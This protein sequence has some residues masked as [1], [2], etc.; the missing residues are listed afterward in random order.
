MRSCNVIT[1]VIM[2]SY[3]VTAIISN[4][5]IFRLTKLIK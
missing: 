2:M 3:D 5:F 1:K 4:I